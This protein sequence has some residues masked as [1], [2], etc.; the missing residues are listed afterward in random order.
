MLSP[1][2]ELVKNPPSITSPLK[3][4]INLLTRLNQQIPVVPV[5]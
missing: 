3:Y 1:F 2:A 4:N 5:V